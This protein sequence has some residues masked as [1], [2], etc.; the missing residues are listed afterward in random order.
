MNLEP[1]HIVSIA[2]GAMSLVGVCFT[3]WVTKRIDKST[4]ETNNAVNHVGPGGVRLY[5]A[6][7]NHGEILIKLDGRVDNIE[8]KL[9]DLPCFKIAPHSYPE[10]N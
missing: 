7:I 5:E 1:Q 4:K 9:H 6:V 2:L 10:E 8:C 3:A